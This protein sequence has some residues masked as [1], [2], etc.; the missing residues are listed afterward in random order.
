MNALYPSQELARYE[1]ATK[2]PEADYGDWVTDGGDGFWMDVATYRE[3]LYGEQPRAYL[4]ACTARQFV[5]VDFSRIVEDIGDNSYDD[6]DSNDLDGVEEFK[7]AIAAFE[8][9]NKDKIVYTADYTR[10]VIVTP[11]NEEKGK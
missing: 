2:I 11:D 4:W 3:S 6:F 9:A 1:W 7:K 5:K 10:A 8:E